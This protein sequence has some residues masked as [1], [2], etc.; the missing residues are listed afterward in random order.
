MWID[1]LL[2]GV[3]VYDELIVLCSSCVDVS[4]DLSSRSSPLRAFVGFD[5]DD[6]DVDDD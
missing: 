6:D 2:A 5:I 3:D 4:S 1:F